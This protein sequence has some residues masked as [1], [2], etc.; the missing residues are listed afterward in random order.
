MSHQRRDCATISPSTMNGFTFIE[1]LITM[2]I[3]AIM[4]VLAVPSFKTSMMNQ[5]ILTQ[6]TALLGALNYARNT[7][8]S[9]NMNMKVCPVGDVSSTTCGAD[10]GAGWMVVTAPTSGSPAILQSHR[11]G[12]LDSVITSTTTAL[13]FDARGLSTTNTHFTLCDTRGGSYARSLEVRSTG[14]VQYSSTMGVAVWD[15]SALACS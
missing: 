2:A 7:A 15:G 9:G 11:T 3:V 14:F 5:R 10:W 12:S 8:L 4:L 13:T 1:L 6:T